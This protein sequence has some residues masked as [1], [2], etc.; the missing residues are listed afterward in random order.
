MPVRLVAN[1][2]TYFAQGTRL[3][4]TKMPHHMMWHFCSQS[5]GA[6][7]LCLGGLPRAS[8]AYMQN[9]SSGGGGIET[10]CEHCEQVILHA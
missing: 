1:F 5:R 8:F 3:L 7:P 9:E 2:V 10:P 6:G 4:Q